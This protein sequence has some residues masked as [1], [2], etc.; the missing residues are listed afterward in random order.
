MSTAREAPIPA[1]P[2]FMFRNVTWA[3]KGKM[4]ILGDQ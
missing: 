4:T 2:P 3:F 1:G